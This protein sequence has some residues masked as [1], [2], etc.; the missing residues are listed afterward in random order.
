MY[1]V[2]DLDKAVEEYRK[3]GFEVEYGRNK[4]PINA[5]IFF[6]KGPYIELL[7]GTKMPLLMKGVLRLLGQGKLVDRL[8]F[9]DAHPVGRPCGLALENYRNELDIERAI[10]KKYGYSCFQV[11]SR[12]NDTKGR[13]LLFK[14]GYPN[15]LQIPFYMTYFNIDPKPKDFVHPNGIV[16]ISHISFGIREELFPLMRELCDDGILD[17]CTGDG[18]QEIKFEYMPGYEN[19]KITM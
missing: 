1:R 4:N 12:R 5:L 15:D 8:D 2:Q 11:N 14:V 6:S 3:K 19:I 13:K 18:I 17:L 9:W 10:L 16:R 7:A